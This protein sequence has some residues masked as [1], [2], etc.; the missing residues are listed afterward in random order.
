MSYRTYLNIGHSSKSNEF[1]KNCLQTENFYTSA[2]WLH[3][4]CMKFYLA[5]CH[6]HCS[7][8]QKQHGY[9]PFLTH[10]LKINTKTDT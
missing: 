7:L 2:Q 8:K 4:R 10:G 6:Y 9:L 5:L 3:G 1:G